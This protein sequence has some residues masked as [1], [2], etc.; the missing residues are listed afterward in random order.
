MAYLYFSAEKA[1]KDP[2]SKFKALMGHKGGLG[3][4]V[5]RHKVYEPLLKGQTAFQGCPKVLFNDCQEV[6]V[7]YIFKMVLLTMEKIF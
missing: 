7:C 5:I 2:V 6:F 4:V 3:K 1:L